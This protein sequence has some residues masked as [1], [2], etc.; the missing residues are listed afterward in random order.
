MMRKYSEVVK[1]SMVRKLTSPGGPSAV[2]L[3]KEVGI[4]HQTLSRWV[5][6]YGNLSPMGKKR[7][8]AEDWSAEK[9]FE[10]IVEAQSLEGQ[11]L[12]EYLRRQGLHSADLE[13][14]KAEI[15][16]GLKPKGRGRPRKDPEIFELRKRE[17]AL[18]GE[19][20]RKEKALAEASALLV[21]KK[22]AELIW[23]VR[24]DEE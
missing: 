17:K 24:E 21:L 3:S 15:L 1:E 4:A 8:R 7:K 6:E 13:R 14:W 22:K 19:L 9:K 5:K 10:A 16:E 18:K 2:Q 11:E 23:G 12:G 20:R